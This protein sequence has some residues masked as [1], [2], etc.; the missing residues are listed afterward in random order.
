[1]LKETTVNRELKAYRAKHGLTQKDMA[2]LIGVDETTYHLKENGKRTF[3]IR[4]VQTLKSK[5]GMSN[6]EAILIFLK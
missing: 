4:E 6:E 5:T 3:N 2:N 1:M